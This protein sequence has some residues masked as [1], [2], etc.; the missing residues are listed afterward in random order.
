MERL[1]PHGLAHPDPD[2]YHVQTAQVDTAHPCDG[3]CTP[4]YL[5]CWTPWAKAEHAWIHYRSHW[6]I[7]Q[8]G[9]VFHLLH[10]DG[11][12][13]NDGWETVG[14]YPSFVYAAAASEPVEV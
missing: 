6:A 11:P 4:V 7:V 13:N 5:N 10:Q 2:D 3:C 14:D 9:D 12:Y 1:C 8:E